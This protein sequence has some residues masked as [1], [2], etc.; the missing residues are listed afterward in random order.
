MREYPANLCPPKLPVSN[1][2][3]RCVMFNWSRPVCLP[4]KKHPW[5]KT[6]EP[7][8]EEAASPLARL[9]APTGP[10][11]PLV[12]DWTWVRPQMATLLELAR[13]NLTTEFSR[14]KREL[15]AVDFHDLEQHALRLLWDR[16]TRKPTAT[17]LQW[18]K[19]L[20]FVFVDEYQDINEAQDAILK[21]LSRE[22]DEA[23]RFLVGDVKQSIYRFRLAD[24]HIF[25]HYAGHLERRIGLRYSVGGYLSQP[26]SNFKLWSMWCSAH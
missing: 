7:F 2:T 22:Y 3:P 21:A 24:P 1:A 16:S 12:Q 25:Q 11:D 19:K 23:N 13:C 14:A 5:P 20:R 4:G 10:A 9:H 15:G 8:F 26:R 17:A 18:R 6:L